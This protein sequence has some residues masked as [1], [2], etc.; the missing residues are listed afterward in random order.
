VN[1]ETTKNRVY[2]YDKEKPIKVFA[3][4]IKEKD[5]SIHQ[6][7][8]GL[9]LPE[10]EV[11]V[12]TEVPGKVLKIYVDEGQKVRKGQTLIK[13]DDSELKTQLS[14]ID[15]KLKNLEKDYNRY[16]ILAENDAIPGVKFEKVKEGLKTAQ[17]QKKSIL[18]KIQNT[19]IKAPFNGYITKKF[20]DLGTF[21]APG[22]PLVALTDIEKLKFTINV[23]SSEIN[24][25]SSGKTYPITVDAYPDLKLNG[26]VVN[27]GEK[28]NMSNKF[29]VQFQVKNTK[30]KK[31]KAN[32]FGKINLDIE[33]KNS[34]VIPEKAIVGSDL[35]PKVYLI[36]TK[37]A[38][39]TPIVTGKRLNNLLIVNEGL[40][41]GDTI[42]TAGFINLFDGAN[43]IPVVEKE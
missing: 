36:K 22:M 3:S 19:T 15:A 13:L 20:V 35:E 5:I 26:K 11:K 34:L 38:K 32:M 29:P 23:P 2:I 41:A 7:Y 31:V 33:Q 10:K 6:N 4:I 8:S 27:L 42:V 14:Q 25:F 24:Y 9:F 28:G 16:K 1:K 43:V 39:L 40:K 17:A 18:I 37:K 30:D 12:N 21:A